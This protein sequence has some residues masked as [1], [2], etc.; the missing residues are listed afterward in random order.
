MEALQFDPAGYRKK[1]PPI[2]R[3]TIKQMIKKID[4]LEK[5]IESLEKPKPGRPKKEKV[6]EDA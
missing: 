5:R 6:V 2:K 1:N 3:E 4:E